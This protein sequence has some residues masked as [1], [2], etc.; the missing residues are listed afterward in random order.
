MADDAIDPVN[1]YL[2]LEPDGA[3]LPLPGGRDFWSQ[4]M[5]GNATDAGIRRL[6]G[7]EKG[8]LLSAMGRLLLIRKGVWHTAKVSE[9]LACWRSPPARALNIA[10]RKTPVVYCSTCFLRFASP[11]E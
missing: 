2:L 9:P 8:R 6:L 1:N 10:R 4:L 11:L 7:S 5:S 3:A